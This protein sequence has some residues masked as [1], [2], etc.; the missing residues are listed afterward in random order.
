MVS[1]GAETGSFDLLL[2][3]KLMIEDSYACLD[4]K[5]S[6]A[7]AQRLQYWLR[8]IEHKPGWYSLKLDISKYFYSKSE[9]NFR[10]SGRYRFCL[11]AFR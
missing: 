7:A 3:Q 5:G 11:R 6:L 2:Y 1:A 9:E 10:T 8:Q 4:D